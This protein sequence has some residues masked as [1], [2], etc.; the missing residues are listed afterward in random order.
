MRRD[1]KI[2]VCDVCD[3]RFLPFRKHHPITK[4]PRDVK[5]LPVALYN[6]KS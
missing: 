6:K 1:V 2:I 3:S 4:I 5:V